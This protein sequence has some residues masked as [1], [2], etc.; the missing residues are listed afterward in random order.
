MSAG[1]PSILV[2]GGAG[3]IGSHTVLALK[4]AGYEV[5]ILDNLVYGHRDLVEQV[6]RV[7][8]IE[9]D[10]SDRLLLDN[11]FQSRNFAAV[12][13]FSAYAYVGESVTD[14]AKYYRNNVLGTLTLLESMLAASIKNFVFSS[15]CATYGVPNF[16]PITEDHPQNPINPYGATKLMVERILTDFDVA[17]NFKSV[18]FRYF[19]AA[20]AN[21]QGLLG[22]DHHPETHLIPLVL[23]TA[24]GKREA[25]SIFGTDYPT[26]DGTC[27]RDYIH[28]N[29]LADAHI[30]GLE[31]LLNG[32]ESEVFNLGNGNGFSVREVIAA[33]EDVTGMVISVQ[34]CDRRI[35]DPP[36]LIGTSEKA[37]KILNWQPQYPGIKDIVSH[38]WQW[39]KTR[40]K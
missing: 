17:Y 19:N 3:Y 38:A 16:I 5:V 31:Y 9:G 36:A 10:T 12:M 4:Q 33:A 28:V 39:H 2:T 21:P 22:E 34:E 15:T 27:I 6:L 23:Q 7:E 14:P 1:K 35:G 24:L 29:D 30:L 8:L 18:R 25:I 20:G 40:H 37:R 26:P 13:H 32:G 11:L